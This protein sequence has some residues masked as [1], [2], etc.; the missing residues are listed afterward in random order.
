MVVD[1]RTMFSCSCWLLTVGRG[2]SLSFGSECLAPRKKERRYVVWV[3]MNAGAWGLVFAFFVFE[4]TGSVSAFSLW[5]GYE[6][7]PILD[8]DALGTRVPTT[9]VWRDGRFQ[10]VND[11]KNAQRPT[12]VSSSPN[13]YARTQS[14]Y[15]T[16]QQPSSSGYPSWHT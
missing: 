8:E 9:V 3:R 10:R 7:G 2:G 16:Y 5:S 13:P 1:G 14:S 11:W 4:S 6:D 12:W 15:P